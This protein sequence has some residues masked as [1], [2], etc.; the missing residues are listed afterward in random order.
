[1]AY[2]FSFKHVDMIAI[3]TN[4]NFVS[5]SYMLYEIRGRE[6]TKSYQHGVQDLVNRVFKIYVRGV[7]GGVVKI[8]L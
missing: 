5:T 1:M 2:V 6:I 4:S 3:F 8:G 7:G